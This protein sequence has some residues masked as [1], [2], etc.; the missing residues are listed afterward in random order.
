MPFFSDAELEDDGLVRIQ[1]DLFDE[2]NHP[3]Q[4]SE[5][6][7]QPV[8]AGVTVVSMDD[9]LELNAPVADMEGETSKRGRPSRSLSAT[10]VQSA[11]KTPK[12]AKSTSSRTPKSAL[13]SA[14]KSSGRKR[15][16]VEIE[17]PNSESE[18]E[19]VE[20][21][22]PAKR[23]RKPAAAPSARLAAKAAKKKG[24]GRPAA[25]NG[26]SAKPKGKGGRPKKDAASDVVPKEEYE[27]EAIIDSMIDPETMEHL[28]FVKWKGYPS[29]ENTWEPKQNLQGATELLRKFNADKKAKKA[30]EGAAKKA[31]KAKTS[32]KAEKAD[33]TD[34]AE[35]KAEKAEK[36][37]EKAAKAPK[38]KPAE[39]KD[40]KPRGRP[41]RP[42][43][44]GKDAKS[45]KETKAPAKGP[46]KVKEVK[47]PKAGTRVSSR[48]KA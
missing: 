33:E 45:A 16:A 43:K 32:Q 23:G 3:R 7:A 13:K 24:P 31:K 39:K 26:T 36:K 46:K 34:K 42:P 29:S 4:V 6:I 27:V 30:E 20:D 28:Y 5:D 14:E 47:V 17:E 41:G 44:A 19:D 12:S 22:A 9:K 35:K 11:S 37:A 21:V 8:P 1:S 40:V 18:E 15:K 48:T 2:Y 38:A 10:P 25:T